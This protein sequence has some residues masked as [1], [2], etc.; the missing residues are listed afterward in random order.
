VKGMELKVSE[1]MSSL[2]GEGKFTG[3]PTTFIRLYG[4]NLRCS[5]C[6]AKYAYDGKELTMTIAKIVEIAKLHG[7]RYICLTGGEPL[8]QDGVYE[9]I[10]Q[11]VDEDFI[12]SI[13]TN[14][15]V[16]I[17]R[18]LDRDYSYCM[19]IKCPSSGMEKLNK[20]SN[21]IN[22]TTQDEVKFVISNREDYEF[23]KRVLEQNI[24]IARTIFSPVFDGDKHNGALLAKWIQQDNLHHVRLGL[25]M[26]KLIGIY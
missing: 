16:Q 23:A 14:G 25:Q 19:D 11:L 6:D 3:L 20:Y 4:C 7:N 5:F 13:E 17:P 9:L 10:H 8:I 1:I 2:Q 24:I 22:L 18:I 21:L 12:V 26:H 15:A